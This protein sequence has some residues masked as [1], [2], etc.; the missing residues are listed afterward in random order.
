[1]DKLRAVARPSYVAP[2]ESESILA[3]VAPVSRVRKLLSRGTV[4]WSRDL[5]RVLA[6]PRRTKPDLNV[7]AEEMTLRLKRPEGTQKL[8]PIQG[9]V[10]WEAPQVGGLIGAIGVGAG[11]ELCGLL[12]PMVMPSCRRAMLLIPASLKIQLLER[13]W[14]FY[15]RHWRLPNLAGGS[16]FVPGKPM[17]H[18]VTY[19]ELSHPKSGVALLEQINPDL[20]IANEAHNLRNRSTSRGRRTL[21]HFANNSETRFCGWSGTLSSDSIKDDA[22][23]MVLALGEN[24]PAPL[25]KPALDEWAAALDP[26]SGGYFFEPGKLVTLC[27]PGE[28]VRLGYRRRFVDTK[29]VVATEE[30]VLGTALV[31]YER[32]APPVP[33]RVQGFLRKLRRSPEEGGWVRPD[34]EELIDA[35]RVAAHARE[36][37]CG[38][39]Y[40]W[41]YPRGEPKELI[42]EWFSRRQSWNRELRDRLKHPRAYLDSPKLAEDATQRYYSGGCDECQRLPE[43]PHARLCQTAKVQPLWHSTSWPAWSEIKAS[44]EYEAEAQWESDFLLQDVAI[45]AK[46]RP[47][48]VWVEHKTF[49][50]KLSQLTGLPYYDE[51]SDE[52]QK[53]LLAEDGSH[54]IIAGVK[55]VRDG[56]NLQG[57]FFRNLIVTVPASAS[58]IEQMV[59]RTH[60]EGQKEDEVEV[61]LYRHTAELVGA[62]EK[63]RERAQFIFET[64]GTPQKLVYG[65]YAFKI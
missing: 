20:V 43:M 32:K 36:M 9:W 3:S 30:G 44:V 51:G 47:G 52:K 65:S 2:D 12:M 10:L 58:L 60:R 6:L 33:D 55:V 59:G 57:A 54:S 45:W 17:L 34:G 5:A 21:R 37:A 48:I 39:Y 25:E 46:E 61:Y 64:K 49:G 40:R 53:A 7:I 13:D 41:K 28:S 56:W 8:R 31:F 14:E 63:A 16:K 24:S 11:K 1:M 35:L 27:N 50:R 38:F 19:S 26:N 18:I 22:H 29:G 23:L 42:D 4:G 15:G 62:L